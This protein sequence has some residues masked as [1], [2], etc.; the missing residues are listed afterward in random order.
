MATIKLSDF[1]MEQEVSTA[2]CED[3]VLEQLQAEIDVAS[4]VAS[5][6]CKQLLMLEY[7]MYQEEDTQTATETQDKKDTKDRWYKTAWEAVKRFF[8]SIGKAIAGFFTGIW[9]KFFAK[10][11]LSAATK[12]CQKMMNASPE[13][14][15]RLGLND[16]NIL[17]LEVRFDAAIKAGNAYC[18]VI[19]KLKEDLANIDKMKDPGT[20][21]ESLEFFDTEFTAVAEAFKKAYDKKDDANSPKTVNII[22]IEAC[23]KRLSEGTKKE[24]DEVTKKVKA[25]N[26]QLTSSFDA[27]TKWVNDMGPDSE[28]SHEARRNGTY[29]T[30]KKSDRDA[31]LAFV[32]D[33]KNTVAKFYKPMLDNLVSVDKDLDGVCTKLLKGINK[34]SSK[35]LETAKS[36]LAKEDDATRIER[37]GGV[38]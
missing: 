4:K 33:A 23:L 12:A 3:I 5:A 9:N 8:T 29:A 13:D 27:A 6:Y 28:A 15:E 18:N 11:K 25:S 32:N 26:E 22:A 2:S 10:D 35:K 20:R 7:A 14:L 30:S 31:M 36:E 1:I 21:Q 24:L 16:I 37:S 34:V 38:R 17:S 19:E